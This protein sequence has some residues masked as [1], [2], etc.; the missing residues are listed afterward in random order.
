MYQQL[1]CFPTEKVL[2][3][4]ESSHALGFWRHSRLVC[5]H[6]SIHLLPMTTHP[7]KWPHHFTFPIDTAWKY[8][9]SACCT[10]PPTASTLGGFRRLAY[11]ALAC[12]TVA[13]PKAHKRQAGRVNHI[14]PR[15]YVRD[16]T[17]QETHPHRPIQPPRWP[18][19]THMTQMARHAFL[20]LPQPRKSTRRAAPSA[21]PSCRTSSS[22][23]RRASV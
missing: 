11:V 18:R 1:V 8:V 10:L 6:S 23:S 22:A 2:L 15:D 7:R 12:S 17:H 13:M 20:H 16:Q 19:P 3:G 21:R 4:V 9:A 14:S 5:L